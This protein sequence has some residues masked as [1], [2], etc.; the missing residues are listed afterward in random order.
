MPSVEDFLLSCPSLCSTR[1]AL[2]DYLSVSLQANPELLPIVEECLAL[3]A[4]QFWLDC[5]TMP[6]VIAAVQVNG[7]RVLWKLFKITRNYCHKL[8]K[9]RMAILESK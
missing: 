4:V 1:E 6:P 2:D 8:H 3:D 9:A 7:E 5:S